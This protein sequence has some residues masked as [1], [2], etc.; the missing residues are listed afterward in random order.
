MP[1]KETWQN[2]GQR[3]RYL[4]KSNRLTLKQLAKGCDL[5]PNAVSLVE[6]GQVAP[7]VATLC[8]LAH[9]LGVSASSLFQEVCST[10]VYLRR[11]SGAWSKNQTGAV[12][13]ALTCGLSDAVCRS[14]SEA[15]GPG[16]KTIT[17]APEP[18][19]QSVL[20]LCGQ[21]EY[22]VDDQIYCLE[23]GD[24]LSFNVDAFHRWRNPGSATGIAIL[25][26]PPEALSELEEENE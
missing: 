21:V 22:E 17:Q 3:I 26:L 16:E 14:R 8:K 23:P 20:C 24:T 13:E 4:R 18:G 7:S 9:A 1:A 12:F 11:A 6:R 10:E 25:I 15:G 5:S 2:I 19:L